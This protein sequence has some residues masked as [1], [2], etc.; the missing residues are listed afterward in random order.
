MIRII[1]LATAALMLF[2]T[3]RSLV[4]GRID[5]ARVNISKA[6]NPIA[7]AASIAAIG[8]L[9]AAMIYLGIR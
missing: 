4:T 8:L 7:F 1:F 9:T 6:T 2:Q 5:G 3:L